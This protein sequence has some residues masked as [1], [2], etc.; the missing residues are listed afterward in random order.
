MVQIHY[1]PQGDLI[2]CSSDNELHLKL[3]AYFIERSG[4]NVE[5]PN[6]VAKNFDTFAQLEGSQ[7]IATFSSQINLAECLVNFEFKQI[8]DYGSGIG[9]LV[10][11]LLKLTDGKI[12][13]V[14]KNKWCREQFNSNLRTLEGKNIQRI[15]LVSEIDF[16][17]FDAVIIDDE[18]SRKDIGGLLKNTN[19][20]FIFIE[21]YRNKTVGQISKRLPFFGFSGKFIRCKSRLQ[22]HQRTDKARRI[23]E[24]AGAYFI[25]SRCHKVG[26]F[27]SW[28]KR[29]NATREIQ[30]VGK[31]LYFWLR[32]T[33]SIRK[34]LINLK[35]ID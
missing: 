9:T 23:E 11:I 26:N 31:E 21:G 20:K 8:L 14:E 18:I 6:L 12:C 34:R 24:K 33:L 28:L 35:K 19:L 15:N 29:I 3:L 17:P 27:K 30:E 7:H 1:P 5:V 4:D 13:A 25:L 22:E 16:K 2:G 10:P 32:R